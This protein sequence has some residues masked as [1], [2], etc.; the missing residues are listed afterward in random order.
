MAENNELKGA[1]FFFDWEDIIAE[2]TDEEQGEVL[3]L[4]YRAAKNQNFEM[5][6]QGT[7]L[8]VRM[9]IKD[10]MPKMRKGVEGKMN[11]IEKVAAPGR[12]KA[13]NEDDLRQFFKDNP[14]ATAKDAGEFFGC[15]DKTIRRSD[16]WKERD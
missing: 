8:G 11:F 4:L 7:T 10:L 12:R 3:L 9:A 6:N 2:L 13:Y 1:T 15:S 14:K 16:A 5:K